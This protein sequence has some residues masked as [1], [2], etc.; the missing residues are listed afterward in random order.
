MRRKNEVTKL[1]NGM[2][3]IELVRPLPSKLSLH[4]ALLTGS[5]RGSTVSIDKDGRII[6]V[7]CHPNEWEDFIRAHTNPNQAD[8]LIKEFRA[9][10][11]D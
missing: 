8:R 6:A 11:A 4:L 1:Q 9:T 5:R 7:T 10:L 3:R 2:V